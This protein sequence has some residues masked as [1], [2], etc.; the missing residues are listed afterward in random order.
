[1]ENVSATNPFQELTA[2][3][4]HAFS[5]LQE[6][7]IFTEKFGYYAVVALIRK[8]LVV[9]YHGTENDLKPICY[10]GPDEVRKKYAFNQ[11]SGYWVSYLE[12]N[13]E[14]SE[15]LLNE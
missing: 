4:A 8:N 3:T 2:K 10:G 7:M 11:Q 14:F 13:K 1:M 6:G 15:K 9:I 5:N 12:T